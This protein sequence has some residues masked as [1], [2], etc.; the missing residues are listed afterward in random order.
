M[1]YLMAKFKQ[2]GRPAYHYQ[3]ATGKA[4][5]TK[6]AAVTAAKLYFKKHTNTSLSDVL[7]VKEVERYSLVTTLVKK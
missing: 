2:Y 1:Y 7:I 6:G 3:S 4:Y 5:K